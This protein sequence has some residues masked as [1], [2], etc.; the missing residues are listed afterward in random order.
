MCVRVCAGVLLSEVDGGA[1]SCFPLLAPPISIEGE[2]PP[3]L[4]FLIDVLKIQIFFLFLYFVTPRPPSSN[5]S[6]PIHPPAAAPC[7]D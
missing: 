2:G 1:S 6:P 5:C 4:R 7:W 3:P